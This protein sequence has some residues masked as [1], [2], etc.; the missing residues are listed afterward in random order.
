[1]IGDAEGW[2]DHATRLH[3]GRSPFAAHDSRTGIIQHH[4]Y[5]SKLNILVDQMYQHFHVVSTDS[6]P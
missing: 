3:L 4:K 1:M 5:G 2:L 6:R